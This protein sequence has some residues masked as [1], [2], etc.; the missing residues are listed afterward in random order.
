MIAYLII[1]FL[2]LY[3]INRNF[4][5][6]KKLLWLCLCVVL[7]LKF[8][9]PFYNVLRFSVGNFDIDRPITSSIELIEDACKNFKKEGTEAEAMSDG[10]ALNLY[11]ALYRIIKYDNT[12]SNGGLLVSAIDYALPKVINPNKG[13][14]T[15]EKL[16]KKMRISYDQ[17][18]S[19]LLLAYGDFG[20]LGGSLYAV[21]LYLLVLSCYA[22]IYKCCI[23]VFPRDGLI[24][25]ILIV[26]NL[27]NL[28][29]N[30][31]GRLDGCFASIIKF[32]LFVFILVLLGR[33]KILYCKSIK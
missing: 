4:F 26:C 23:N 2:I 21:F 5:S 27:I 6:L 9:F 15:A 14:G 25:G 20:V 24:I 11:Y 28:S 7:I 1:F 18:D 13:A 17:A 22:F 29:F 12:P 10:R 19:F 8:Y 32:P 30:V 33:L 3:S 31:E 16:E